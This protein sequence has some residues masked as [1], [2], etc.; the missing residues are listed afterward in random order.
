MHPKN[1]PLSQE[2]VKRRRSA[3]INSFPP[4]NLLL[5]NLS[6]SYKST[7]NLAS[8]EPMF[9]SNS[10]F[11]YQELDQFSSFC[12][13]GSIQSKL[14]SSQNNNMNNNNST[15]L[16]EFEQSDSCEESFDNN[17]DMSED[18]I[19]LKKYSK[20]M[21]KRKS[22][23]NVI[24]PYFKNLS[25]FN[26]S[27][28]PIPNNNFS[29]SDKKMNTN[30]NNNSFVN[31]NNFMVNNNYPY[32]MRRGSYSINQFRNDLLFN[33]ILYQNQNKFIFHPN[34]IE[35]NNKN[36]INEKNNYLNNN[37]IINNNQN[38]NYM[39]N[40][41]NPNSS[42]NFI[43]NF[44]YINYINPNSNNIINQNKNTKKRNSLIL[45]KQIQPSQ[46]IE[47]R[48][49][50]IPLTSNFQN[51]LN[52]KQNEK[53]KIKEENPSFFLKD[54]NYCR[55][56]Q[57]KLEKNINNIK[58]SE[59]FYENIKPRLIEIIEHQFGNYVIQKFLSLLLSQENK[60]IFENIFL[61]IKE[62]LYSIC[63][64]NYGTRVIQKT[65]E[66]LENGNYS[67]IETEKLNSVFQSLIE[68]HLYELCCDKNGNHV[69]QKLLRIFPKENNK[70]NFLFDELIKISYEVSIIQQG[71]TLLGV[72]FDQGN[73]EQKQKLSEAIIE[74]IGDLII[75]KYGNYTIQTV[76]KLYNEKINE[77]IFKYIDDNLLRLSKEKFSSNVIDKFIIKD[78]EPSTALIQSIINK[79]IIKD[80]IVDQYGNYVV[81]KALNVSDR[82]TC[83]KIFEQIKPM[84]GELQ[85]TNIGKK[86]YEKL[87]QHYK[88]FFD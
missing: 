80:I 8:A 83:E 50:S 63:V 44:P 68:K 48:R 67:K 3:Q 70:N 60:L 13:D 57:T 33:N 53:S 43:P 15:K 65:L 66:K 28:E 52:E 4:I 38:M 11:A 54:Q 71:A 73:E 16:E 62:Q 56:I 42:F 69:Y 29:N 36:N 40:I 76:F 49:L 81:Q 46:I 9:K 39:P 5:N 51:L 27:N 35:N 47:H 88:D 24:P 61:E 7:S 17:N 78:Y 26:K 75:D 77:K 84:L 14:L 41:Q 55:Q 18:E 74:R 25:S 2:D 30:E 22:A 85:K 23:L 31:N 64:H 79:N 45:N 19:S 20:Q 82:G 37:N 72:A 59:E 34:K 86:I 6:T 1:F 58:Y 32:N 12:D 21:D 10:L 87:W